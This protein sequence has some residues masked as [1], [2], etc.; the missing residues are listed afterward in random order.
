MRTW[1]M[2]HKMY[3]NMDDNAQNVWEHGWWSTKC[4]RTWMIMHKMYEN[5]D[6]DAQNVW[7]HG[8]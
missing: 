3:E 2:M 8:W 7:E 6:D 1:M 4:M 5:M